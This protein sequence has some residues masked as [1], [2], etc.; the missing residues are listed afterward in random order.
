MH[1]SKFVFREQTR[2]KRGPLGVVASH[3]VS[4]LISEDDN[5]DDIAFAS[6]MLNASERRKARNLTFES[7]LSYQDKP[8]NFAKETV[9]KRV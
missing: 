2:L 8:G 3:C 5:D 6:I 9:V 1:R 4:S 7:H